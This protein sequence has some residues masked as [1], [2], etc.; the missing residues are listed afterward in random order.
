MASKIQR[1]TPAADAPRKA[2]NRDSDEGAPKRR[3]FARKIPA[4]LL[5]EFTINLSTLSDAGIPIVRALSILEGQLRPGPFK[6]VLS[7]VRDEVESGTAMSE[8]M[9]K[10]PSAFDRLYCNMVKAGETGGA[11]DAILMRL[12]VFMERTRS[13]RDK[14]K[15]AMTYPI[16]VVFVALL[17]IGIVFTF[18]IPKFREIFDSFDIE[19]PSLTRALIGASD[20]FVKWWWAI[21]LGLLV[22]I[23]LFRFCM[24]RFYGF[25]LFVHRLLLRVPVAGIMIER[26]V[27]ARFS[28]T[29]GTLISSGVPHLEA[30]EI[31]RGAVGNEVLRRAI[32]D[33]R[34]SVREGE[35]IAE[36]LGESGVFDD[37]VTNMV[38]VGEETGTLDVMLLKIADAYE[39][40]ADRRIEVFFKVLEPALLV[41]MAVVVGIIVAALF[42]PLLGI[43]EQL[44]RR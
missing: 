39:A 32:E 37:M 7:D 21:L 1:K 34:V 43:M 16:V 8:A 23:I 25:R 22:P 3:F 35:S 24:G 11:L 2:A 19:L 4:A 41:V 9:K 40:E 20:F 12:A 27:V 13:I 26:L 14:A 10:H 28:R 18:V 5:T 30:L 31:V 29:F 36:P 42:L 15:G 17:V 44:S 33:V 6:R 38:D